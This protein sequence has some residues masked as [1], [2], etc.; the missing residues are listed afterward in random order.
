M[1]LPLYSLQEARQSYAQVLSPLLARMPSVFAEDSIDADEGGLNL[2]IHA[3]A[4][5]R[6]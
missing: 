3:L 5:L 2:C 6:V 4:L 1:L